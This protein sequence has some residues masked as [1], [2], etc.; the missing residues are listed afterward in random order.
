[1]SAI[2]A[3]ARVLILDAD[4]NDAFNL[5]LARDKLA[6]ALIATDP[7]TFAME[8][9]EDRVYGAF[10]YAL[11]RAW[12]A[13][14][15]PK[16]TGLGDVASKISEHL[17]PVDPR[18]RF[19]GDPGASVFSGLF[20][21][22]DLWRAAQLRKPAAVSPRLLAVCEQA[23]WPRGQQLRGRALAAAGRYDEALELLKPV[24]ADDGPGAWAEVASVAIE[25]GRWDDALVAVAEVE[26]AAPARAA[27]ERL[28]ASH[29]KALLVGVSS[30]AD[31][32][33]PAAQGAG[34]DVAAVRRLLLDNG[35]DEREITV[36]ADAEA[37]HDRLLAEFR[38][39]AGHGKEQL[40]VFYVAGNGS[41]TPEGEPTIVPYD[42]RAGG[43][44]D[45]TLA[46]LAAEARN[47]PN[48]ITI[49]DAGCG[50]TGAEPGSRAA[51]ATRGIGIPTQPDTPVVGAVTMAA[52]MP[53]PLGTGG[54]TARE[55]PVRKKVHGLL[56][57]ALVA[58]AGAGRT[59]EDWA[60][61]VDRAVPAL[62]VTAAGPGAKER[63]FRHR[64]RQA[65]VDAALLALETAPAVRAV[66]LVQRQA[67]RLEERN[68]QSP[69]VYL[70]LGLAY[71]AAGKPQDAKRFFRTARNL[72]DDPAIRARELDRDPQVRVWERE[73][74]YHLGRLLYQ[75]TDA[76][77]ELTDAVAS[78]RRAHQQAPGDARI[79][80]HLALAIR[81]LVERQSLVEVADLLHAYLAAGA[82]LGRVEEVRAAL[83]APGAA[84]GTGAG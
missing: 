31:P 65:A 61:A 1:V 7:G 11:V 10:T 13:F 62:G 17:R 73:A 82:P 26:E 50:Y 15:D 59:Y 12:G 5:L 76:A 75:D 63:P 43:A 34:N 41:R 32:A 2:P 16:T 68:E 80:L 72:Y 27:I 44:Q 38:Q 14:D 67:A 30:H 51:G 25:A 84:E 42:G 49:L 18:P 36:L 57:D 46:E 6:N 24:A 77:D 74:C 23:T 8:R 37:T 39:L 47:A 3:A 55:R 52:S 69:P 21:A 35:F 83:A 22:A 79:V 81:A 29:P 70:E 54:W 19:F 66:E 64:T 48:L 58:Q 9:A 71:A 33:L 4:G 20:A 45:V 53:G 78:L 60:R 28:A 40:A 56:T